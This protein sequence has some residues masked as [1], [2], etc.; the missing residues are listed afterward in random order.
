MIIKTILQKSGIG[1]LIFFVFILIVNLISSGFDVINYEPADK[2]PTQIEQTEPTEIT[3]PDVVL[4][5]SEPKVS[6]IPLPEVLPETKLPPENQIVPKP[7]ET[8]KAQPEPIKE[9]TVEPKLEPQPIEVPINN[10]MARV[11]EIMNKYQTFANPITEFH[12]GPLHPDCAAV[13]ADACVITGSIV[14]PDGTTEVKQIDM[15]LQPHLLTEYLVVHEI[16]HTNGITDECQ[17]DI[18]TNEIMGMPA[19][20]GHY[21]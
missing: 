1:L 17:A 2:Q 11:T 7:K 15:Y 10:N 9:T 8:A 3:A 21:C 16:Q 19:G 13:A 14:Y 18:A 4:P 5:K 20:S 6:A 12:F